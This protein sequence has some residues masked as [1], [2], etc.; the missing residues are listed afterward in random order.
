MRRGF[1]FYTTDDY[2]YK[3]GQNVG[4]Q[5]SVENPK[6]Y[7]IE[8]CESTDEQFGYIETRDPCLHELTKF[9]LVGQQSN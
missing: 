9:M 5:S 2:K 6:L 4:K 1:V 8:R 3:F 7:V